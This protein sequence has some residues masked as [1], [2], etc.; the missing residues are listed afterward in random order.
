M[1]SFKRFSILLVTAVIIIST[2]TAQQ[3]KEMT[4]EESYLQ[5]SIE[6]MIIRETARSYSA[7]QKLIALEY[8]GEALNRG[9]TNDEIRQTLEFLSREGIKSTARENGRVVN[10][11]TYI[12]RQS[13]KYL[14]QIGTEE[15]RKA[16]IGVINE[17]NEPWVLQEIIKSLGDIGLNPNNETVSKIQWVIN[18]YIHTDKPDN[19]MA[20]AAIDA[21]D[22][23]AKKNNGISDPETIRTLMSISDGIFITAVR[24]RAKQLLAELRS[25]GK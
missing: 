16:L 15:A 18:R 19:V 9:S 7:G 13:A 10:N 21:F 23:I 24:E 8:I 17:E 14:G 20:L 1:F 12:R 25:Y 22:K 3:K 5:E 11:F 4:P 6:M 2:A